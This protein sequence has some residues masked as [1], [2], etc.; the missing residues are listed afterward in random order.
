V[1]ARIVWLAVTVVLYVASRRAQQLA[2]GSP[3]LNPVLL[4]AAVIVC[5]IFGSGRSIEEYRSAGAPLLWLLGPATVALAVPLYRA[6]AQ[7]RS[8]LAPALAA[9]VVGSAATVVSAVAIG[10]FLG[11]TLDTERALAAKSVTTP[12]AMAITDQIGGIPALAAVF[13]MITGSLGAVFGTVIFDRIGVG[14]PRARGI[15]M[16]VVAHGMGTARAFQL[17]TVM[18][19]FSGIA[20]TVNGVLTAV[21]LPIAWVL[22][23]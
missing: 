4:A 20:M 14:D 3:L 12:I 11:A 22:S 9:L 17:S 8:A 10:H 6:M 13:V 15:A 16:G 7:V 2:K 19:T 21:V 18:G 1:I 23:R 5:A